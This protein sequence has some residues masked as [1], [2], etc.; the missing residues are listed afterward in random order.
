MMAR[1]HVAPHLPE[2][3]GSYH[4]AYNV[5]DFL[6]RQVQWLPDGGVERK[7]WAKKDTLEIEGKDWG[8][9]ELSK[10]EFVSILVGL[11]LFYHDTLKLCDKVS[12]VE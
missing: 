1:Y 10:K 8:R 5:L 9:L 7:A 6:R 2:L 11:G 4:Q 12:K 3:V